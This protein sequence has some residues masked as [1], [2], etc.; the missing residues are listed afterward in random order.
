MGTSGPAGWMCRTGMDRLGSGTRC[1]RHLVAPA[2]LDRHLPCPLKT[3]TT[4]STTFHHHHHHQLHSRKGHNTKTKMRG[5]PWTLG[6]LVR[7]GMWPIRLRPTLAC[8]WTHFDAGSVSRLSSFRTG[9]GFV[10]FGPSV[11][12]RRRR[13]PILPSFLSADIGRTTP[14]RHP[15]PTGT[16]SSFLV[17][18]RPQGTTLFNTPTSPQDIRF[19]PRSTHPRR[20]GISFVYTPPP[21]PPVHRVTRTSARHHVLYYIL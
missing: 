1:P 17:P 11:I 2:S 6:R 20:Q 21:C 9:V 19:P 3:T 5:R 10:V 16:F 4:T 18:Q 15:T 8:G 7:R 14:T 13:P 12:P